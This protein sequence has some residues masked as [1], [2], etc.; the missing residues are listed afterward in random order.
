MMVIGEAETVNIVES[1][2]EISR[3][4]SSE[5]ASSSIGA[6]RA[7]GRDPNRKSSIE[8]VKRSLKDSPIGDADA[9]TNG[10]ASRR[11]SLSADVANSLMK[12]RPSQGAALLTRQNSENL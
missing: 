2:K 9:R 7:N 5:M 12:R 11:Q 8:D 6:A 3:R 10:P 4:C 1:K